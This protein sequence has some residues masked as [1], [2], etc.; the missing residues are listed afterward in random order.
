MAYGNGSFDGVTFSYGSET[1]HSNATPLE[2]QDTLSGA[3]VVFFG[4]KRLSVWSVRAT[5][6]LAAYNSLKTKYD[7]ATSGTLTTEVGYSGTARITDMG[8]AEGEG[9]D[10]L[11]A[12]LS[13]II[14]A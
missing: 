11:E 5:L 14:T 8:M 7:A 6:T 9:P 2:E 13:F 3:K 1:A 4:Y 12:N 10:N